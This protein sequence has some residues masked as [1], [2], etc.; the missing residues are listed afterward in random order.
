[1]IYQHINRIIK[2]SI[3]KLLVEEFGIISGLEPFCDY[4]IERFFNKIAD[5]CLNN[6]EYNDN[7][8]IIIDISW[9]VNHIKCENWYG[10]DKLK[11]IILK[12]T[13]NSDYDASLCFDDE[14]SQLMPELY[15][16][17]KDGFT[18]KELYHYLKLYGKKDI[19]NEFYS[20]YKPSIMHELTHLIE[21]VNTWGNYKYPAYAYM[22]DG[23]YKN[24]SSLKNIGD[25]SFAFSKTEMNARVTTIYYTILNDEGLK[26]TIRNWNG[27]RRDLC[28]YLIEK[29]TNYNWTSS[30]KRY[31]GIIN[32]AIKKG[33][34]VYIDFVR[35]F[36]NIN[37]LA[38][39]SGSKNL[40]RFKYKSDQNNKEQMADWDDSDENILRMAPAL[41]DKMYKMY[42]T[43]LKK[44]YKVADLAINEVKNEQ[45]V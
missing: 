1:M 3:D 4:I 37:K 28:K 31:L 11:R 14:V 29:T 32:L 42:Y 16:D 12:T 23:D 6:P 40:F 34:K 17:L 24:Q 39:F 8:S 44:L 15:I 5:G 22:N 27:E 45:T 9:A 33:D 18:K 21:V 10:I 43:Y 19:F 35:D 13:V 38:A 41:Y 36:I 26:E 2:E 30:I 25:V 20:K 7:V